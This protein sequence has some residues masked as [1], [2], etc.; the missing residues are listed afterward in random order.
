MQITLPSV[1]EEDDKDTNSYNNEGDNYPC[2]KSGI[3]PS[4]RNQLT[5][6]CCSCCCCCCYEYKS[7]VL[8]SLCFI[9][10]SNRI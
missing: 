1:Q 9:D 10:M 7:F 5:L 2:Y 4:I 3:N 6:S 8:L